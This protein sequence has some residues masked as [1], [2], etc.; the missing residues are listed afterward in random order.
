MYERSTSSRYG[1]LFSL[2]SLI[3][4]TTPWLPIKSSMFSMFFNMTVDMSLRLIETTHTFR[5]I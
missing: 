3:A 5:N 4:H 1:L 2:V